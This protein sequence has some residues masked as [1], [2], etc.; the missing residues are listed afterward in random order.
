VLSTDG[1]QELQ[2]EFGGLSFA[3]TG[4]SRDN[5]SL[6]ALITLHEVIRVVGDGEDVWRELTQLALLVLFDVLA[7]V[8]VEELIR[9]D[10]DKDGA[11]ISLNKMISFQG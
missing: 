2:N 7:I 6:V 9:V 10:S 3:G 1:R 8:N 5:D 4:F 11:S